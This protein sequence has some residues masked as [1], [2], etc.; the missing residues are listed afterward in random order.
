MPFIVPDLFF[1]IAQTIEEGIWRLI[2]QLRFRPL[3]LVKAGC[4]IFQIIGNSLPR[5][6]SLCLPSLKP[7]RNGTLLLFYYP[8]MFGIR[9]YYILDFA[10]SAADALLKCLIPICF[11]GIPYNLP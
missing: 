9:I 11:N 3:D 10:G 8:P 5:W 7:F 4:F 1:I 2:C 6:L